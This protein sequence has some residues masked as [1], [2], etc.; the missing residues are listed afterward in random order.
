MIDAYYYH[1][2]RLLNAIQAINDDFFINCKAAI[3]A[4]DVRIRTLQRRFNEQTFKF[5]RLSINKAFNDQ[6]E[7]TVRNY[8]DRLDALDLSARFRMIINAANCLI[9]Q[10]ERV[11]IHM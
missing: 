2:T 5:T 3:E 6:Q 10:E 9:R 7:Q 4:H 1:E 8:I 11:V